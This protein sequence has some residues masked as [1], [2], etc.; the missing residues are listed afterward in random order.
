MVFSF[1]FK[2][3]KVYAVLQSF[4]NDFQIVAPLYAKQFSPSFVFN[5]GGLRSRLELRSVL[6]F[7]ADMLLKRKS[8]CDGA[9]L[10]IVL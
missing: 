2:V 8:R 6:F 3:G 5:L 1:A 7:I 9:W 4:G 10:F